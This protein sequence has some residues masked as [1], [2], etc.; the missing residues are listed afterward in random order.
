MK[1]LVKFELYKIFSKK[2]VLV[3]LVGC[4]V[5]SLSNTVTSYLDI[6]SKGLS[7]SS[8]QKIGKEYEGKIITEKKHDIFKKQCGD[9]LTKYNN[10]KMLSDKEK[11]KAFGMTDYLIWI[12]P[13]YMINGK[14]YKFDDMKKELKRLEKE[15]DT[16]SYQ[17]KELKYIH[18]LVSKKETPKYYFKFGWREATNF[19]MNCMWISIL[20]LVS[21]CTI[22]SNEYQSNTA[23]IV[24]S[25]KN[26]QKKLTTAKIITGLI[27]STFVFL[28][29]NGIQVIILAMHGFK[30]WDVPM[31]FLASYVRTPYTMNIG[32]FYVYGLIVSFIGT[33]LFTLLIMLVSLISKNNMISFA[34]SVAMLL[35][36][37]FIGRFMPTYNL[38]KIFAEL[39]I[40]NLI[41]PISMF[42]SIST[43]NIFGK[44]VL[45]LNV[46]VTIGIISIPIVLYFINR[47]GKKQVV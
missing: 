1:D 36:P 33:V 41:G 34:V 17:Y 23:S 15:G 45:Y 22:F 29:M 24:L 6:R 16:N 44:P 10:G 40:E 47:I 20:I 39:N 18:D 14:L 30:G 35:G 12:N 19:N 32:T 42:G 4:I 38:T 8:I 9:L 3:L 21:I 31:S 13:E 37:E 7:Y 2:I 25:S 43:Y 27:F 46:I 11:V 26:G 5:A 28:I